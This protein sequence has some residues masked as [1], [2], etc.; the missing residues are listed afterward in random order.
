[1][2][3]YA[4][5]AQ[6]RLARGLPACVPDCLGLDATSFNGV[7]QSG[8]FSI[9]PLRYKNG[10]LRPGIYHLQIWLDLTATSTPGLPMVQE[11]DVPVHD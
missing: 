7:V 10:P 3:P 2:L 9:G 11:V 8:E 1:M 6:T 4:P 5:D